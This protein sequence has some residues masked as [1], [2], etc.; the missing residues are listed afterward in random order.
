MADTLKAIRNKYLGKLNNID[1]DIA[2]EFGP[3]EAEYDKLRKEIKN[4]KK[5]NDMKAEKQ[6][7]YD[8]YNKEFV[9]QYNRL[10][11]KKNRTKEEEKELKRLVELNDEIIPKINAKNREISKLTREYQKKFDKIEKKSEKVYGKIKAVVK[12]IRMMDRFTIFMNVA[13]EEQI[14]KFKDLLECEMDPL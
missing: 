2:K 9:N 5:L 10:N 1:K 12:F 8:R 13:S 3:I 7:L 4:N 14:K 6:K 11:R